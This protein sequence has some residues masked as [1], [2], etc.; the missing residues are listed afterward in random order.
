MPSTKLLS[1]PSAF[2][3]YEPLTETVVISCCILLETV[4]ISLIMLDNV[5]CFQVV[6]QVHSIVELLFLFFYLL[7]LTIH[8]KQ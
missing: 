2:Y 1:I 6:C 7:N 3:I 5:K 4:R 8:I